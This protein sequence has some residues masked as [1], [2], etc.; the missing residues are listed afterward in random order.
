[1]TALETLERRMGALASRAG[2]DALSRDLFL[3][4]LRDA[5]RGEG[6]LP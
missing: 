4:S 2:A 5:S 1:M 6:E 3:A